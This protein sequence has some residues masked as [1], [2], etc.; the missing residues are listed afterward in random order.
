VLGPATAGLLYQA[1]APAAPY[2][3]GALGMV[4]A[5]ALALGLAHLPAPPPRAR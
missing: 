2:L 5:G 1:I 4:L 3:V